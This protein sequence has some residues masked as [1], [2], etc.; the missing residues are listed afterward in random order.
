MAYNK[1]CSLDYL[2]FNSIAKF[3]FAK[4]EEV[5]TSF[6]KFTSMEDA[7]VGYTPPGT[8]LIKEAPG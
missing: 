1:D 3:P 8:S 5:L 6:L 4:S 7:Q 2:N